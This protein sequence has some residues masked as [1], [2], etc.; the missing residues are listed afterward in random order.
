MYFA[1][2]PR[3]DQGMIHPCCLPT[4]KEDRDLIH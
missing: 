4:K 1:Q 3:R 2:Y